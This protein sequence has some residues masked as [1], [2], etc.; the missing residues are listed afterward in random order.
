MPARYRRDLGARFKTFRDNPRTFLGAP[1]PMRRCATRRLRLTMITGTFLF[2]ST[3]VIIH[4]PS[5]ALSSAPNDNHP[6]CTLGRWDARTGY[7]PALRQRIPDDVDR[8]T[9][10]ASKCHG[11]GFA[12]SRDVDDLPTAVTS[13]RPT[14]SCYE[15]DIALG[16]NAFEKNR[17]A[18]KWALRTKSL[19]A[20][21]PALYL[22][23]ISTGDFLEVLTALL[24]KD[25]PNLRR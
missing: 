23:R 19:D 12:D 8:P 24:D 1:M 5:R 18:A 11:M 14:L 21:L 15:K 6:T 4:V 20:L 22:R 17:L 3:I 7:A 25:T 10:T 2:A 9:T 13:T 16:R